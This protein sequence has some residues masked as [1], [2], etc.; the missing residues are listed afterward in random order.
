[1]SNDC[2]RS[3]SQTEDMETGTQRNRL[4]DNCV[5][6]VEGVPI[7]LMDDDL[8]EAKLAC[9]ALPLA[10]HGAHRFLRMSFR[11]SVRYVMCRFNTTP[12]QKEL[13]PSLE[14]LPRM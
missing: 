1:M 2:L 8:N 10:T 14:A 6:Y 11:P 4:Q 5:G 3:R 13:P 9:L 12:G 7:V